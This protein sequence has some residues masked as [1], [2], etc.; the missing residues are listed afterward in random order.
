[1]VDFLYPYIF[2]ACL[3]KPTT[4]HSSTFD[5]GSKQTVGKFRHALNNIKSLAQVDTV[6]EVVRE[7]N[8]LMDQLIE[9]GSFIEY[10]FFERIFN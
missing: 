1:M 5:K 9:L 8:H 6:W 2:K 4:S 10:L 7:I 3:V